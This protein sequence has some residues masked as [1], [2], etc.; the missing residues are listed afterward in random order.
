ME[1]FE[2][3]D[4]RLELGRP[5][6]SGV[7]EGLPAVVVRHALANKGSLTQLYGGELR[8]RFDLSAQG[9]PVA[10]R[11][12]AAGSVVAALNAQRS[13]ALAK[14][15]AA[16]ASMALA[17]KLSVANAKTES[18]AA[19]SSSS[20]A[21]LLSPSVPSV[22]KKAAAKENS[23]KKRGTSGVGDGGENDPVRE[24]SKRKSTAV[25]YEEAD[26]SHG[27]GPYEE[28]DDSDEGA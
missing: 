24:P 7:E 23:P 25:T 8:R 3:N 15:S 5:R 9:H 1:G 10:W 26:A 17:E 4:L 6:R 13:A 19:A 27:D 18:I 16:E 2:A 22:T 21:I 11:Q 28:A 12:E 14:A 20:S